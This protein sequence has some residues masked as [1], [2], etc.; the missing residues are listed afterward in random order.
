MKKE[1]GRWQ[2]PPFS[3][4]YILKLAYRTFSL[5]ICACFSFFFS[6][7]SPGSPGRSLSLQPSMLW[8]LFYCFFTPRS[9]CRAVARKSKGGCSLPYASSV[10]LDTRL[11]FFFLASSPSS[12]GRSSSETVLKPLTVWR[13][14]MSPSLKHYMNPLHIYC[15]LRNLGLAKTWAAFLV[16]FY[17]RRIFNRYVVSRD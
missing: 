2:N 1:N 9:T 4:F 11:L 13:T 10:A 8:F 14:L 5:W 12:L 15:R 16:R 6:P 7:S 3:F 17:E